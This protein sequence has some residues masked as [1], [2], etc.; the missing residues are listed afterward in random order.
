[1]PAENNILNFFSFPYFSL[2]SSPF[3]FFLSFLSFFPFS[4]FLSLSSFLPFFLFFFFVSRSSGGKHS[5]SICVKSRGTRQNSHGMDQKIR[6]IVMTHL[7]IIIYASPPAVRQAIYKHSPQILQY[8]H[9]AFFLLVKLCFSFVQIDWFKTYSTA[10]GRICTACSHARRVA[11]YT[12]A[13]RSSRFHNMAN[14]K[15]KTPHSH[16]GSADSPLEYWKLC[17]VMTIRK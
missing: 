16:Q 17:K 4:F 9:C 1:M 2:L 5:D 15:F 7:K 6:H 11:F 13:R 3:S 10:A 12:H 14:L 8:L